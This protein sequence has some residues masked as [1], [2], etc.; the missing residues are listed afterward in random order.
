M[1]YG[2]L[3]S[4]MI[5]SSLWQQPD[6]VRLV[7]VTMLALATGDGVVEASVPGLAHAAV[8]SLDK[9]QDA[10]R[11]LMGPDPYSTTPAN[12][13]RRL[14]PCSGGWRILNFELYR[15]RASEENRKERNADRMRR[16]RLAKKN[17]NDSNG[18]AL[19]ARSCTNVLEVHQQQQQQQQQPEL[20]AQ[21][22]P[23]STEPPPHDRSL[24]GDPPPGSSSAPA[25][26]TT[27]G[28]F[29]FELERW[30]LGV[31]KGLGRGFAPTTIPFKAVARLREALDA[32]KAEGVSSLDWLEASGERF[33]RLADVARYDLEAHGYLKWL[34]DGEPDKGAPKP[35]KFATQTSSSGVVTYNALPEAPEFPLTLEEELEALKPKP[36]KP[37]TAKAAP[38]QP[39]TTTTDPS[40]TDEDLE[41]RKRK[42]LEALK[43]HPE[44]FDEETKATHG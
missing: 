4:S 10:L 11:R 40:P 1:P 36:K 5:T 18:V 35:S 14:A 33:G 8:V 31:K 23:I 29:G 24:Q 2:R 38:S 39:R 12:E 7:W 20:Q 26:P 3:F 19:C 22:D 44:L 30:K 41:D 28:A 16:I 21:P 13:G 34:N 42:Q 15:V 32:H 17:I 43:D 25:K 27:V 9:T 6:H 37:T